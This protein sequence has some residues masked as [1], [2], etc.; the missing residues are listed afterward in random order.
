MKLNSIA[1]TLTDLAGMDA[2][3]EAVELELSVLMLT[4]SPLYLLLEQIAVNQ[5]QMILR[6]AQVYLQKSQSRF[7]QVIAN[8]LHMKTLL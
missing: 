2:E 5:H 6:Q 3:S 8:G 4:N 1:N 7:N